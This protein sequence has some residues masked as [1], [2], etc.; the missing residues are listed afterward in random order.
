MIKRYCDICGDELDPL[1]S[2]RLKRKLGR[3]EIEITHTFDG[4]TNSGDICHACI[5]K[6]VAKGNDC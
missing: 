5:A 6:A 1:E 4:V 3:L 2:R